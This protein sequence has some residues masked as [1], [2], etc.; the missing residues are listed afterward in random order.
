MKRFL[1]LL[2]VL[3]WVPYTFSQL[4]FTVPWV[5]P[6]A[7]KNKGD[8]ARYLRTIP[9]DMD[10]NSLP[11]AIAY[12]P[13]GTRASMPIISNVQ[14]APVTG[15]ELAELISS[16]VIGPE[17][18]IRAEDFS[19][20]GNRTTRFLVSPLR[21]NAQGNVERLM[22][23]TIGYTPLS[24]VSEPESAGQKSAS[25]SVLASGSFHKL[26]VTKNAVYKLTYENLVSWGVISGSVP[27]S[28]IRLYGN[29][30][31]MLPERMNMPR[32]DDL[33]EN[34]IYMS[35]GGSGTFGPGAY[36]LFYAQG[37]DIWTQDT[38]TGR[39][40]MSRHLY[41]DTS[42]YFITSQGTGGLRIPSRTSEPGTA[43][44]VTTSFDDYLHY[45]QDLYNL[46][47]SG[48]MWAGRNFKFAN[49][50][51]TT[52]TFP[53][54]DISAP[55][56]FRTNVFGRCVACPTRFFLN[57]NG[58][59]V[60]TIITPNVNPSYLLPYATTGLSHSSV[61]VSSS[62]LSVK[63]ELDPN[64]STVDD[65][66]AWLDYLEINVRRNLTVADQ[67]LEFRDKNASGLAEYRV[68]NANW[69]VWDITD[70]LKP[71][72]QEGTIDAS[73]FVFRNTVDTLRHYI[74]VNNG[75]FPS[76]VHFGKVASQNL[77][78]LTEVHDVDLIIVSPAEFLPA[79]Q[80]LADFHMMKDGMVVHVVTTEQ[81]YNE[82]S[83]GM[84]DIT[85]IRDF[86][87][88]YR[89]KSSLAGYPR[90]LCLMGDGSFDYKS[91]LN[92]LGYPNTNFVPS[93]QSANS[94]GR[95]GE[96]YTSDD[97]YAYLDPWDIS[98][99]GNIPNSVCNPIYPS[100]NCLAIGV[101]RLPVGS[102]AEAHTMVN[103]IR[104]YVENAE[105]MRDW[106]NNIT[107]VADDMEAGWESQFFYVSEAM[108]TQMETK[109]NEYNVEKIYTDA[110]VQISDAGQRAPGANKALNNRIDRGA[111][112]IN[113]I[114]H[115][116]ESG[117]TSERIL[118]YEDIPLWKNMNSLP[119]FATAT[120][121]F[122]RFDNPEF[123]SAGEVVL[124]EPERGGIALFST[125]RPISVVPQFCRE[126]LDATYTPLNTGE[127][128]RLGDIIDSAK[129]NSTDGGE[130]NILL[131]GDPAMRLAYPLFNVVTDSINGIAAVNVGVTDTLRA[132][133]T[134]TIRGHIEDNGGSLMS[135]FNGT[136]YTTIYDKPSI[137]KTLANDPGATVFS[138]KALKNM[139]YKG[140]CTVK[141]GEF[142]FSF[143][144]PLDINY[145]FG[146][147]KI[148]YYAENGTVD[149]NGYY[150]RFKVGGSEDNCYG[151]EHGPDVEMFMSDTNF[152]NGGITDYTPTLL[153][154]VSDPSGINIV[155]YGLG[156]NITAQI[157]NDPALVFDLNE[158][159][160]SELDDFTKGEFRY[161]LPS[162][163]T[164]FHSVKVR[165]FD[166]CNNMTEKEL[167]FVV[168][169]KDFHMINVR[170]YPN[171]FMHNTRITFEHNRDDEKL[172]AEVFIFDM[173]GRQVKKM[174]MDINS[175]GYRD[176]TVE[177]DGRD[178]AGR[179]Q[180]SGVYICRVR[181]TDASGQPQEGFCKMVYIS[182]N[183]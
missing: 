25:N 161:R 126:L 41:S 133:Q 83:S 152:M 47:H 144:V 157:D 104:N 179:T 73:Q 75:T 45:E 99:N 86:V 62:A 92:R 68:S 71:V 80:E 69:M 163:P 111:L 140:K 5:D 121:T 37:P 181:L 63:I 12:L 114:G 182:P 103:K 7:E 150:T 100:S 158:F 118:Q 128:P 42:Y 174:T 136:L 49:T 57:V 67:Q 31:G 14:T 17:F 58:N 9:G 154:K 38:A 105:C 66:A 98:S 178:D 169:N 115:G 110:Y 1:F 171:P 4:A 50:W 33:E 10:D 172:N 20:R 60:D 138:F 97:Y 95:S 29:G 155:G 94:F 11:L 122:T 46:L 162:L 22:G 77:H 145:A 167:N 19:L 30:G 40:L 74:A 132:S 6:A 21:K 165:V 43:T 156:H 127:M 16:T 176:V 88:M 96:S 70:P 108:A 48:R 18:T 35:D 13:E 91:H 53:N 61:N 89:D 159:Y 183:Q 27:S 32:Y 141:D 151:D 131:Y 93:Y 129:N 175:T 109:Y 135:G 51:D 160:E 143:Q 148:S 8:F 117:W 139:I 180:G 106:R 44:Y 124:L 164:G 56:T 173:S 36:I 2:S 125:S 177:W 107:L 142:S 23:C 123:R 166:G 137:L 85:A 147:G 134:V 59:R 149:A 168:T 72:L 82:Y 15:E 78:A 112:L 76:P 101:G 102:L 87:K 90:Y 79:A 24:S 119:A 153:V 113:Y 120:C 39:Y 28:S 170:N 64:F 34:A 81:I 54:L 52:F 55:V 116:G 146:D 130:Q 3:L 26:G 84:Q 65:N